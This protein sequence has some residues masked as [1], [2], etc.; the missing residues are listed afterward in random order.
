[1][2]QLDTGYQD[3]HLLHIKKCICTYVDHKLFY[4]KVYEINN[5]FIIHIILRYCTSICIYAHCC[6]MGQCFCGLLITTTSH[7]NNICIKIHILILY[8]EHRKFYNHMEEY[9]FMRY[10]FKDILVITWI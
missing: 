7:K 1:M 9:I 10:L 5:V 2:V 6:A 8:I 4:C 3:A